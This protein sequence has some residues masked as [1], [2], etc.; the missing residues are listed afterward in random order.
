IIAVVALIPYRLLAARWS[1][2]AVAV[3]A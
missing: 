3:G 2:P 1:Q